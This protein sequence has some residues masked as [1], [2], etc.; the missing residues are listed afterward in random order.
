MRYAIVKDG[1]VVNVAAWDGECKWTPGEGCQAIRSDDAGI[2]DSY[3]GA[4]FIPLARSA[5][6]PDAEA[7]KAE[8]QRRIYVSFSAETQANMNGYITL[9]VIGSIPTT[10]ADI[11]LYGRAVTWINTMR[12]R[13]SELV[14]NP[15]Y[16]DDKS[17]PDLGP[18]LTAFAARF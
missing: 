10:E 9:M 4:A 14:G 11:N 18:D 1:T 5:A 16:A 17:W 12:G 2:G 6:L 13:A 3:D 8:C 7:V 15:A